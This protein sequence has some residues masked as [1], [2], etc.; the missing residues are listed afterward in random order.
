M[1]SGRAAEGLS[2]TNCLL[3]HRARVALT[4]LVFQENVQENVLK[5]LVCFGRTAL[6]CRD[7]KQAGSTPNQF[8]VMQVRH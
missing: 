5:V 4:H 2:R 8:S 3:S 1:N 7:D 6:V